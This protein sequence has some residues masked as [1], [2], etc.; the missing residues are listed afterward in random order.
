MHLHAAL[1]SNIPHSWV[2]RRTAH[3]TYALSNLHQGPLIELGRNL[4]A[5]TLSFR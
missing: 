2:L 4:N 3:V 5:S 1:R